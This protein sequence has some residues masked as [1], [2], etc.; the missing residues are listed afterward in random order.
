MSEVLTPEV[1]A[2]IRLSL[3][4]AMWS[5][6]FGLPLAMGVAHLLVRCRF[7]GRP[8]LDALVHV[9]LVLPPVVTGYFLLILLGRQGLL[10]EALARLDLAFAFRPA[11]AVIAAAV[12]A[13]PLMVRALRLSLEA[14][15]P[16]LEETART[17]GAGR[18]GTWRSVTLPLMLPGI[19]AAALLGFAKAMGEFGATITFVGNTP[20]D[21]QT[22][23]SAIYA[24][25]QVPGQEASVAVLVG[26]SILLSVGAL[27]VSELLARWWKRRDA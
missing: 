21:T 19:L 17:L 8:V 27:A 13:F 10:G 5:V 20:F 2:A 11:G 4:V 6:L 12:M 9:P 7:W 24:L 16:G 1:W 18:F 14:V 26:I 23:P 22:L 25:L 3:W 15:D